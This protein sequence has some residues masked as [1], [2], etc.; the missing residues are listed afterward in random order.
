MVV[1]GCNELIF[2]PLIDWWRMGP[3]TKQLRTFVWS[4]A[5]VHYKISMMACTLLTC[6]MEAS[7]YSPLQTCSR[8]VR[9]HL[10][11]GRS[12]YSYLC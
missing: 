12:N 3:I 5:P 8:T 1:L 10:D 11:D 6:Y 4:S 7:T 2:N 9:T